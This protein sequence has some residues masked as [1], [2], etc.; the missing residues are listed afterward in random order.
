MVQVNLFAKVPF[1]N[2]FKIEVLPTLES[3]TKITLK[4]NVLDSSIS[5]FSSKFELFKSIPFFL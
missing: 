3:P 2:F 4:S 5:N 1:I